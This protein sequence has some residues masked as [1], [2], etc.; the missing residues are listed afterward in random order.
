MLSTLRKRVRVVMIVV[1]AAFVAG[2]LMSE[3]W[4][5]LGPGRHRRPQE[6]GL[7]GRVGKHAITYDEYRSAHAYITDKYRR[8][9]RIRDLSNED[10]ANIEQQ[11]WRFLI[12]ELT[13]AKVLKDANIRVTQE[14]VFEIMKA[15]PPEQLRDDPN[16]MTD[17]KFD[18]EKYMQAMNA[19]ENRA[20]FTQYFRDLV[21]MLPKEKFRIDASIAYRVTDGEVEEALRETNFKLRATALLFGPQVVK[22]HFEPSEADVR[23]Y[24]EKHKNDYRTRAT[25]QPTYV[26]FPLTLTA[27]DSQAA[28][29]LIDKAYD[30]L[31]RGDSF[32]ATALDF[33]D[34]EPDTASVFFS[35]SR[36]DPK[37]D[38]VVRGLKP[39]SY[40]APFLT[41]Y[42]WQIVLLDSL[43]GDSVALRRILVRVKKGG[44]ALAALR[45]SVR[46]FVERTKNEPFDSVA[47]RYGLQVLRPRPMLDGKATF[48]ELALESPSQLIEWAK[49]AR[50][51]E[52]MESP[53]RGMNGYYVFHMA[54]VKPAGFQEF[55]KVKPAVTW[56]LRQE[57]ERVAWLAVAESAWSQV[58]SG[59][60][61]DQCAHDFP[62][63]EMIAGELYESVRDARARRGAEFAGALSVLEPG[64]ATGVVALNWGAYIIRCD[65]RIEAPVL[66]AD[67]YVQQRQQQVVQ[68]LLR[69]LLK[70][71]EIKDYRDGLAY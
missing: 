24:Y 40:S 3:L 20:V 49:R 23:A 38:T 10:Y 6:M 12:G 15:N 69:E 9:N 7:V 30:Q 1:A 53:L 41:N 57:K 5:M 61:L 63:V 60:S 37:T 51:K 59:K 64:E 32:N 22:T 21:E 39:G 14:E 65:E 43:R 19:P 71:P 55:D 31:V 44:E 34:L 17:G 52:V 18:H 28:K 26:V 45:D 58:K 56:K 35:R 42:G 67:A 4:R 27:T 2:F 13:W 54:E 25:R 36:L 48:D 33:S 62:G 70:E 16:L 68:E 50:P 8:E 11:T 66:T 47:A 29:E 46:G